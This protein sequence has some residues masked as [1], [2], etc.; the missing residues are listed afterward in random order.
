MIDADN[1]S[2][3]KVI[4]GK[5]TIAVLSAG[6]PQNPSVAGLQLALIH[7][8]SEGQPQLLIDQSAPVRLL[9]LDVRSSSAVRTYP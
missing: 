8:R 7:C 9:T 3:A 6:G 2:G 4:K 5:R 1:N